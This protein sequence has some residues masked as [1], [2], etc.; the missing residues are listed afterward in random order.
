MKPGEITYRLS[1]NDSWIL[2]VQKKSN[3]KC[4][5]PECHFGDIFNQLE[6]TVICLSLHTAEIINQPGVL[7]FKSRSSINALC[8]LGQMIYLISALASSVLS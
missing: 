5:D 6:K 3:M 2:P 8:G 1:I 4:L 7:G